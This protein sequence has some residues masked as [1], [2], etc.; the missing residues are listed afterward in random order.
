MWSNEEIEPCTRAR[1]LDVTGL[2]K[3]QNLIP[4]LQERWCSG[5]NPVSTHQLNKLLGASQWNGDIA[6]VTRIGRIEL[7]VKLALANITTEAWMKQAS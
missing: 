2:W 4:V 7:P 3:R 1:G 5:N 6:T